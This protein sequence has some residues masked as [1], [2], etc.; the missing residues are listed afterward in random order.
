[1]REQFISFLVRWA[2]NSFGIWVAVQLV[3]TL[4]LGA[5]FT[6]ANEFGTVVL[7]GLVF[8]LVNAILKP[9][10]I[11]LS[12]PAILLTLGLFILVVNGLMVYISAAFVPGIEMTF[13]AAVVAGIVMSLVNYL[14]TG[15]FDLRRKD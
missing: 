3:S 8:S 6:G 15:A 11:I 2:L 9:V 7:V 1:M 13:G 4:G 14:V 5:S 12:L 10:A